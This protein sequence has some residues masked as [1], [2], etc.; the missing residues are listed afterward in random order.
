MATVPNTDA[1]QCFLPSST[2][3]VPD[4]RRST[5]S[6]V[7]IL[8]EGTFLHFLRIEAKR[9][10]RSSG[11]F[12]LM[13]LDVRAVPHRG[14]HERSLTQLN[15]ALHASIRDTDTLGWYEDHKKIGVIFT[16]I[17]SQKSEGGRIILKRVRATLQQRLR[18][19]DFGVLQISAQVYPAEKSSVSDHMR[20]SSG[21]LRAAAVHAG[22]ESSL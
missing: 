3:V 17:G 12:M 13:L 7:A 15:A 10:M 18:F 8:D 20:V 4:A 5:H 21:Q 1:L 9:A 2:K 6:Q 22:A 11:A 14:Q 16:A 19:E